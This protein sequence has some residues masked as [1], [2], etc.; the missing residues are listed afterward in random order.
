[1]SSQNT[2]VGSARRLYWLSSVQLSPRQSSDTVPVT[3]W[4]YVTVF[5]LLFVCAVMNIFIT[6]VIHS[7]EVTH[8]PSA[9]FPPRRPLP[10]SPREAAL[11]ATGRSESPTPHLLPLSLLGARHRWCQPTQSRLC[12]ELHHRPTH[13]TRSPTCNTTTSS[14]PSIT[15]RSALPGGATAG[16]RRPA[17]GVRSS[18]RPGLDER[19]CN[20][21]ASSEAWIGTTIA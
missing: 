17:E 5:M 18:I 6:I 19:R 7:Y 8:E 13:I 10:P 12:R 15:T 3:G 4:I 16:S 9:P 11:R 1:M 14:T 20:S 21:G 2:P